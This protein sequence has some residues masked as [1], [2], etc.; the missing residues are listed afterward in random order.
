MENLKEIALK[1][2]KEMR[3]KSEYDALDLVCNAE[4]FAEALLAE[5]AKENEPIG[6]IQNGKFQWNTDG[7]PDK[8]RKRKDYTGMLYTFPPATVQVRTSAVLER[9]LRIF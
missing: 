9:F 6:S 5:I 3:D 8:W 1:V 4:P 2:A 7:G